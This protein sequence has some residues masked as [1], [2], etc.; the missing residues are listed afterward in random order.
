[1]LGLRRIHYPLNKNWLEFTKTFRKKSKFQILS[2]LKHSA[3]DTIVKPSV[4]C[5]GQFLRRKNC[6][7][8]KSK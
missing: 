3:Y 5:F 2:V 8:K 6:A 7:L 1:M 4:K